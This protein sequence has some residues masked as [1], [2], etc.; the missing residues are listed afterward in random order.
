M[1]NKIKMMKYLKLFE[2]FENE[3]EKNIRMNQPGETKRWMGGISEINE[4]VKELREVMD[5]MKEAERQV[6]ELQ[7]SLGVSDLISEQNRLME[8]IKVGMSSISKSTHKA[9]GLILK[10]RKGTVRWDPPT[11]TLMLEIVA[12][13]VDGAKDFIERMKTESEF[14]NPVKVKPSLKV[15]YDDEN[16]TEAEMMEKNPWYKRMWDKLTNWLTSFRR[17]VIDVSNEL[18]SKVKELEMRLEE[19]SM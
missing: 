4:K 14:K 18:D 12:L 6:E 2:N 11:K 17:K 5:L 7:K 9:Y 3:S 8:D 19:Q 16:V 15:E 1:K 13:A 10:H